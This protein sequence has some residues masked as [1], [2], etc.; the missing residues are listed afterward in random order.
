MESSSVVAGLVELLS[1]HMSSLFL[2]FRVTYVL[3][4]IRAA[5]AQGEREDFHDSIVLAMNQK[6]TDGTSS[7]YSRPCYGYR[8]AE[9]G[10]LA[11]IPEEAENVR[12]IFELYLSGK[13]IVGIM[14]EL[15]QRNILS[16]TGK[17]TWSRRAID[18]LLSN[19]KYRGN[20]IAS[21]ARMSND[22]RS[23]PRDRYLF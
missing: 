10:S 4:S 13:S 15:T 6:V 1:Y 8:K 2:C 20:S 23:K 11:I 14:R 7:I 19:E 21:T 5:I 22:P 9:D 18:T 12:L 3:Y 17:A 16:P